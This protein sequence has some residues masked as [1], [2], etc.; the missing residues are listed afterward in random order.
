MFTFNTYKSI[1]KALVTKKSPYYVQFYINGKCNLKCRQCNIVETN[2]RVTEMSLDEISIAAKNLKK[3]G[4][5][6]VLLTGGEPFMRKD[7]PQIV[8][9]FTRNSL[10]V[11]LQTAGTH[12]ATEQMLRD[13]YD[14]GAR[15]INVSVDSLN[16]DTSDYINAVPGSGKN[17]VETIELI[18]RIFKKDSAILSFG[19]VLSQFNYRE[20]PAILEFAKRIGWF[21]SMVPVHIAREANPMGFRSYDDFFK[22]RKSQ[23]H[24]LDELGQELINLKRGGAPLFDSEKFIESGISFLKG[25]AP[26]WRKNNVCDS[27]NLYFAIRPN[28]DFSTC[29]D[30]TLNAPP[31]LKD[32]GFSSLY[33]NGQI[34]KRKD[35]TTIVKNCEGC[36]YGSYP[37][38]TIS[39]RDP[40]AFIERSL[41]VTKFGKNKLAHAEVQFDFVKE[42]ER[43]KTKYS[44]VYPVEN[45]M[46]SENYERISKWSTIEGRKELVAEDQEIRKS[47][48]RIRGKGEDYIYPIT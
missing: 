2:S 21:V 41:M 7:L 33:L 6:I 18:S 22:F 26:T 12:Y 45:W 36:H 1:L 44:N 38:V 29:C 9:I 17:A 32:P 14:A 23:Y 47:Q 24:Y 4:G 27:P 37:E 13:C 40:K 48:N 5:A 34:Q 16:F 25:N 35:V 46:T 42:I 20:M 15:D 3:I 43:I 31:S 30:Y 39:V 11:R 10:N 28:G 19:T 8:E